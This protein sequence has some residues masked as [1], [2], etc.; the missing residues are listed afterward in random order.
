MAE[1]VKFSVSLDA[2]LGEALRQC[3]AAEDEQLSVVVSRALEQYLD[4]RR[5][6]R[7]GMRAMEEHFDEH[8]WPTPEER[9]E[10]SAWVDDLF[11]ET[12]EERRSA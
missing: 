8:G 1:K 5:I 10:A 11:G 4:K 12:S 2:E 7:E 9:A 6:L 3:A